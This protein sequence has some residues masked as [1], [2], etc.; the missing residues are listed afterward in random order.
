LKWN[1]EESLYVVWAFYKNGH[2]VV[3][4]KEVGVAAKQMEAAERQLLIT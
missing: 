4:Q 3:G 1:V 2:H